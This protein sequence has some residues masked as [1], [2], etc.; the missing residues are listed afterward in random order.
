MWHS[1]LTKICFVAIIA[2]RFFSGPAVNAASDLEHTVDELPY[3]VAL[4]DFFQDKYFSSIT[5]ILVAKKN[6]TIVDEDKTAEL[7]LGSMYLSY[8]LQDQAHKIF[9]NITLNERRNIPQNILDKAW[10][11]MGKNYYMNGLEEKSKHAFLFINNNQS[12]TLGSV[13]ES[14]RLNILSEIYMHDYQYDDALKLLEQFP[15]NSIWKE[16]TQFNLGVNLIKNG[17]SG[18]GLL[19]LERLAESQ[20]FNN[21]LGILHDQAN[22]ALAATYEK[23]G[24]PDISIKYFERIKLKNPQSNSALLGLGWLKFK[25]ASYDDALRTWLQLSKHSKTDADVQEALMLVPYTLEKRGE[26]LNALAQYDFAIQTYAQQL[27]KIEKAKTFIM[28]GE[29][30]RI[31]KSIAVSKAGPVSH[32]VIQMMGP[33]LSDYLFELITSTGFKKIVNSYYELA[34]LSNTLSKWEQTI[35]SLNLILDEK[36]NTYNSRLVAV[37]NSLKLEY[38]NKLQQRRSKL[39]DRLEEISESDTPKILVNKEEKKLFRMLDKVKTRLDAIGSGDPEVMELRVKYNFL[40]GILKWNINTDFAPR[41][42]VIKESIGE[43]DNALQG[44]KRAIASLTSAWQTAPAEHKRFREAIEGKKERIETLQL[45]IAQAMSMHEQKVQIMAETA[46][47][48]HRDYLKK[49]HDRALFSKARVYDSM[50]MKN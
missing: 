8:G 19:L 46:M 44:V 11:H 47:Q 10:F 14:E 15:K 30:I 5:G 2:T 33:E 48:Q 38:V 21:E 26:K 43:L 35:P 37:I 40:I 32:N 50:V 24:K 13:Y 1:K 34:A 28:Q 25:K 49:Y 27:K 42:L 41:F 7:L 29:V 31:L 39:V 18:E 45:E 17:R 23:M 6:Q 4:Y 36:I 9:E 22:L 20:L 3:G 16:Y 12:S